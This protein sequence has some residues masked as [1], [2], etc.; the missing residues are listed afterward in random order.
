MLI[1][2][3][4]GENSWTDGTAL[5]YESQHIPPAWLDRV[6]TYVDPKHYFPNYNRVALRVDGGK[7]EIIM[8]WPTE[9]TA[10]FV[11][12]PYPDDDDKVYVHGIGRGAGETVWID[13][14]NILGF[15][16]W[17]YEKQGE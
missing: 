12:M 4:D 3:H 13:E 6:G 15:M 14:Q 7:L 10:K 1:E 9:G 8:T 17:R 16:G 5:K 2:K 11:L